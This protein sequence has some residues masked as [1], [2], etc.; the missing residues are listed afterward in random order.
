VC[1][2]LDRGDGYM[3][4]VITVHLASVPDL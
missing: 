2:Q 4:T 3:H 1:Y